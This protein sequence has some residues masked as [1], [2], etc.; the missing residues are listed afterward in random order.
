MHHMA[1]WFSG[2]VF[3]AH[4][5]HVEC[6]ACQIYVFILEVFCSFFIVHF[7]TFCFIVG[8]CLHLIQWKKCR[9]CQCQYF[10]RLYFNSNKQMKFL[11]FFFQTDGKVHLTRISIKIRNISK[12]GFYKLAS[13]KVAMQN[14]THQNLHSLS[15]Q[16][17]KD[18]LFH[19]FFL[20][21]FLILERNSFIIWIKNRKEIKKQNFTVECFWITVKFC[22]PH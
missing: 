10:C 6:A 4:T 13:Q 16:N 20:N 8:M 14:S 21:L 11:F 19:L 9:F 18:P 17:Y 2:I 22:I 5:M 3:Y 1:I 15:K 7:V 12:M